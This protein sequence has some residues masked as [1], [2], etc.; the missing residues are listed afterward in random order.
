MG[1]IIGFIIIVGGILGLYKVFQDFTATQKAKSNKYIAKL[2][3]LIQ[4]HLAEEDLAETED[5][6]YTAEGNFFRI[7]AMLNEAERN[8]FPVQPTLASAL[9]GTSAPKGA[10]KMIEEQVMQNYSMAK[11]LGV[12]K[13]PKNMLSMEIGETPLADV[14]GWDDE[15][16]A[17]GH[18]LSPLLAPEAAKSL[19]NL[20]L[21]PKSV[22]DMENGSLGSFGREHAIKWS[23]EGVITMESAR[24][25]VEKIEGPLE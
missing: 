19:V 7:I 6:T 18:M 11:S 3:P 15:P 23:R 4:V 16:L 12:F 24:A 14:P 2:R 21:Q 22:R 25:I 9:S 17:V 5:P 20:V 1:K 8:Q 10:A 13:D